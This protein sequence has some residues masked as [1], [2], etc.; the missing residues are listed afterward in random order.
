MHGHRRIGLLAASAALVITTVGAGAASAAA[1]ERY[2]WTNHVDGPALDCPDFTA[3]GEWDISHEL[4]L[5]LDQAGTPASDLER[6]AF[7]G[8]FYNPETQV[9]VADRGTKR[10]LDTFAADGS[11]ASTIFTYQR[12][13]RFVGE[14]G[15]VVLGPQDAFG[16]QAELRSVGHE[17]FTDTNIA[18]LC[19]ALS[20]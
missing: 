19:A 18:A 10:F 13:D 2:S 7:S 1:P 20:Q 17:G 11:Y 3:Y 16:D 8:R 12:I 6:I 15:R 4:T 9:S 14:A 5:Y